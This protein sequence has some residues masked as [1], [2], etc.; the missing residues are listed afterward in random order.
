MSILTRLGALIRGAALPQPRPGSGLSQ[1]LLWLG[2]GPIDA[3]PIRTKQEQLSSSVGWAYVAVNRIGMDIRG[4]DRKL[5]KRTG[6][7]TDDWEEIPEDQVP[8]I[9]SRP[10]GSM[11][12]GEFVQT[13]VMHLDL[14]GEAYWHLIT[15]SEA[16]GK[17]IG[18]QLV[19]PHW[20]DEPILDQ[21]GRITGWRIT[22]PGRSYYTVAAEDMVFLKYPHPMDPL[23]GMS[24]VE[25][26]A[27]THDMDTYARAYASTLLKNRATPELVISVESEL[28]PE[29]SKLIREG[30]MDKYTDPRNGPAVLGKG[31][32]VQQLGLNIAD[33]RFL[34]LTQASRETILAIYGVP[35]AAVGLTTDFNR[36]NAKT[37]RATYWGSCISP[38][39]DLI[40]EAMNLR[41]MP[42]LKGRD[43][44]ATENLWW[45]FDSPN[46]E[47]DDFALRQADSMFQRG[48]ITLNE[49]RERLGKD[50]LGKDG[51]VYYMPM[52]VNVVSALS[53]VTDLED[54]HDPA[55]VPMDPAAPPPAGNDNP[56][57]PEEGEE[58]PEEKVAARYMGEIKSLISNLP[59][60]I[61]KAPDSKVMRMRAAKAEFL[62]SQER[63]ERSL[64]SEVRKLFSK[65]QAALIKRLKKEG[66]RGIPHL[67]KSFVSGHQSRDWTDD[68]LE[69]HTADWESAL[70][71][72]ILRG[73]R[74]GWALAAMDLPRSIDWTLYR[75]EAE[76]YARNLSSKKVTQITET[77]R[78]G[79]RKII[80]DGIAS[81][82]SVDDMSDDLRRLYDGFKGIRAN[83]IARTETAN[84]SN[85]GKAAQV[86]E[87]E[88]RLDLK[89]VKTWV[90]VQDDRTREDHVAADGQ[91]VLN[92]D[93]FTVGGEQLD[94]PGDPNG[95]AATV[96]NCRCTCTFAE[97]E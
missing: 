13:T 72:H 1:A 82:A 65:E 76:D 19:Y 49:Y 22:I 96:I 37:A 39:L 16:G 54:E 26:Y 88:E 55:P 23:R 62:R 91:T 59:A 90:S 15:A 27:I 84:S 38:R 74:E 87:T 24:P 3:N 14:T 28:T 69:E 8:P 70:R 50:N 95:S 58:D 79:V 48:A 10:D 93:Q 2:T 57:K 46:L 35:A 75:K 64:K 47:D 20:V 11:T 56:P 83:T 33:L 53:H 42:R 25:A 9:L 6:K 44:R 89:L 4:A 45:G 30:W 52:G 17:V 77:T 7:K 18:I 73:I 34:E 78:T 41:V 43:L 12:I 68:E 29:Q 36:A 61:Q 51:D 60:V 63:L 85:F 94:F 80:G 32:K 66:A 71:D 81:G 97:A 5:W 40:E 31:S 67:Q 92:S 21:V 86:N